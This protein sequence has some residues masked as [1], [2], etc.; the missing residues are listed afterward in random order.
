MTPDDHRTPPATTD[1]SP[2]AAATSTGDYADHDATSATPV[3]APPQIPLGRIPVL[4]VKPSVD[5][6]ARPAKAVPG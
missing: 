2:D 5:G 4:D 6:G 1:L 3:S